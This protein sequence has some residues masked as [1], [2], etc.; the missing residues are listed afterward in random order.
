MARS[1]SPVIL[2]PVEPPLLGS[3]NEDIIDVQSEQETV[4]MDSRLKTSGM[5][6]P[7]I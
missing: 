4:K 5:G 2:V 3:Y 1:R 6:S 7:E